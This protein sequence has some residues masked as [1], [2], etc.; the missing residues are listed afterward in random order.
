MNSTER[1][2]RL[3]AINSEL[4]RRNLKPLPKLGDTKEGEVEI[5]GIKEVYDHSADFFT[6]VKFDVIFPNG[7]PGEYTIRFNANGLVSDGAVFVTLVNSR[8]AIIKQW[9]PALGHWMYEIPRG[10]GEKIDSAKLKGT[11]GT[12]RIG[13]LPL[14]TL[15]RELTEEVM[16]T[17]EVTTI[18]HLGNIAQD[19]GTC[20]VSPSYFLVQ[21]QVDEALLDKRIAGTESDLQVKLWD[22]TRVRAEIGKK[23][24]DNHTLAALCLALRYIETLPRSS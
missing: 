15:I 23:L 3:K 19:S 12:I 2:G 16:D 17:A 20:A 8:F 6:D 5:I 18:T 22:I 4:K 21:L 10:F 9:R 13:D 1:K 24:C 14:G 11:L 7:T